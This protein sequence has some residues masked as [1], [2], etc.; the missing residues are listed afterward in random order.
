MRSKIK[1]VF[2]GEELEYEVVAPSEAD[3]L[4]GKISYHSPLGQNLLGKE[5][6]KEC[7]FMAGN[8][9]VKVK[10]IEIK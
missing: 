10:I 6:G 8:K 4:K 5:T 9:R 7:D 3:I 2:D 1:I